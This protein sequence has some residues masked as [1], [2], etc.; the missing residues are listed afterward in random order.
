M[1]RQAEEEKVD[2]ETKRSKED[3]ETK[4]DEERGW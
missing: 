4:I 3:D 2:G 1:V